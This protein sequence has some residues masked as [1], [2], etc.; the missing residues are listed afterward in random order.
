MHTTIIL[1]NFLEHGLFLLLKMIY[2]IYIYIYIYLFIRVIT[3]TYILKTIFVYLFSCKQFLNDYTHHEASTHWRTRRRYSRLLLTNMFA[4]SILAGESGFG[5][6]SSCW[7]DCKTVPSEYVATH[8]FC[9]ISRHIF[10]SRYMF[11]WK[12][13]VRNLIN[14]GSEG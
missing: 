11:G 3:R 13:L 9:N 4:A 5:S 10:P 12:Q 14:G 1:S 2:T 7:I 8:S 6:A